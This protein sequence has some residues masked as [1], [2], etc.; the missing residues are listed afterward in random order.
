ME[1]LN[2]VKRKGAEATLNKGKRMLK[3]AGV[4]Y[5]LPFNLLEGSLL[6][7][8]V[9]VVHDA[10]EHRYHDYQEHHEGEG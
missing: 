8:V 1:M 3:G 10:G 4:S 6:S 9:G 5:C 7:G 2:K